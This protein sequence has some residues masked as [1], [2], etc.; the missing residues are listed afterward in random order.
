[1]EINTRQD[2]ILD[3]IFSREPVMKNNVEMRELF[4]HG[5]E[6]CCEHRIITCDIVVKVL[7]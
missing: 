7:T 5:N 3:L 4:K 2:F 6:F 1:M